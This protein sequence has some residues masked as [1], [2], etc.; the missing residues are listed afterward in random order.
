MT[1][2]DVGDPTRPPH[3]GCGRVPDEH[4]PPELVPLITRAAMSPR[5][6][7]LV[8]SARGWTQRDLANH[9]HCSRSTIS[10]L[11]TG[12]QP[13]DDVATAASPKF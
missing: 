8:R 12:A 4:K 9:L 1:P 5:L 3:P 10:R 6:G 7:L 13:L 11:E 2:G